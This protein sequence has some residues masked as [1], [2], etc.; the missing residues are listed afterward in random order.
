[1]FGPADFG[2][3]PVD[4]A[5]KRGSDCK[6]STKETIYWLGERISWI[7][8]DLVSYQAWKS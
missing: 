5:K 1:M 3:A 7:S 8:S 4:L 6:R 2:N